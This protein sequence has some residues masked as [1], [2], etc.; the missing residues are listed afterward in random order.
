MRVKHRGDARALIVDEMFR[1]A[2]ARALAVLAREIKARDECTDDE[3][4]DRAMKEYDRLVLRAREYRGDLREAQEKKCR[5]DALRA[6]GMPTLR[7]RLGD[8]TGGLAALRA[9]LPKGPAR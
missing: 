3:A 8:V 7:T 1:E 5:E 4:V 9:K 2:L 6:R